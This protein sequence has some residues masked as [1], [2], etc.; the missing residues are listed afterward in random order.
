[1]LLSPDCPRALPVQHLWH[2]SVVSDPLHPLPH[3][4]GERPGQHHSLLPLVR[5]R[6]HH[7][8]LLHFTARHLQPV[9][10]WLEGSAGRRCSSGDGGDRHRGDQHSAETEAGVSACGAA[11]LGLPPSVG[12]LA[13]PLGQ[14]GWCVYRQMLL[15]LQMLPVC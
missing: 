8:L 1:M 7:L 3:P 2:H 4:A 15:L 10:G 13:L 11:V 14:S 9:A 6:L 5:C 12:S